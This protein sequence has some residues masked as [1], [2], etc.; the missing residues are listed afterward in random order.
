LIFEAAF[1]LDKGNQLNVKAKDSIMGKQ[2]F[3]G[4]GTSNL[5]FSANWKTLRQNAA[6]E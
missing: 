6:A 1:E 2:G 3:I 5:S 4:S